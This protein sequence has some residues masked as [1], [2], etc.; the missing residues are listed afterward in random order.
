MAVLAKKSD[1]AI[2]QDVINELKWDSRV[3]STE[4]GVSVHKGVV[5]LTGTVDTWAKRLAAQEAAHRVEGV[6]D[7]ANDLVVRP[8]GYGVRDD[9]EIARDVRSALQWD[10][11]VPDERIRTTVDRGTVL[12]EGQVDS[13]AQSEDAARAIR[14]LSGVRGV[15]NRLTVKAATMHADDLRNVVMDTLK[16]HAVQEA[17]R[18][19]VSIDEG[20][21]TLTG[22]VS[23]WARREAVVAAVRNMRGVRRVEDRVRV[24]QPSGP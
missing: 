22:V 19:V 5:T 24:E 12:L 18:V 1:G 21:V 15:V 20:V 16:R 11:L 23:S 17:N 7:V 9:T 4:V 8:V 2:Q 10:V 3:A 6:L 13:F 14:N